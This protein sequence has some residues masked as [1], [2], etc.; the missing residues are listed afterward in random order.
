MDLHNYSLFLKDVSFLLIM[1][2]N[3]SLIELPNKITEPQLHDHVVKSL[4]VT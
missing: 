2:T 4:F 1:D 3:V